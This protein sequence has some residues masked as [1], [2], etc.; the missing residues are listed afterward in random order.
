MAS[1]KAKNRKKKKTPEA[2][3]GAHRGQNGNFTGQGQRTGSN[4]WPQTKEKTGWEEVE[5]CLGYKRRE[6]SGGGADS[7]LYPIY[8]TGASGIETNY[9]DAIR[10]S[11]IGGT[12]KG[13]ARS[14]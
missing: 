12:I 13:Y 7:Y 6:P 14:C 4:R 11:R 9:K 5:N 10:V 1:N 2:S 8:S 3:G